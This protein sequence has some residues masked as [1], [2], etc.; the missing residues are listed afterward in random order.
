[1]NKLAICGEENR[2]PWWHS[3]LGACYRLNGWGFKYWREQDFLYTFG[4]A[5]RSIQSSVWW[6]LG[7]FPG[8]TA[9]RALCWPPTP[10]CHQCCCEWV[11]PYHYLPFVPACHAIAR[12]LPLTLWMGRLAFVYQYRQELFSYPSIHCPIQLM[13][14]LF[15]VMVKR[16]ICEADC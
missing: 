2:Q 1:M 12:N 4:L 13:S 11:K 10:V 7:L 8:G 14:K 16:L 6:V 15:S 3:W 9:V 5:L